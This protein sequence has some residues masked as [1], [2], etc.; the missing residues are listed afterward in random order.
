MGV[1]KVI[2]EK[3]GDKRYASECRHLNILSDMN[4][5]E[6]DEAP[7]PVEMLLAA[8]ASC[9]LVT[10]CELANKYSIVFSSVK[11]EVEAET[12]RGDLIEGT[13]MKKGLIKEMRQTYY[14]QT[15]HSK[16]D[17]EKYLYIVDG[18]CT[19]GNSLSES[20]QHYNEIVISQADT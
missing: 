3:A 15:N 7:S 12:G 18:M 16:E 13:H 4:H 2:T 17:I 14:I 20:I 11:L 5:N 1:Y 10:F 19:V 8:V 6:T 9:K